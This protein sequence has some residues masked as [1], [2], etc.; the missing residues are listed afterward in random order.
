[1]IFTYTVYISFEK[2]EVWLDRS[3]PIP[4]WDWSR[5]RDH[6]W[7]LPTLFY[8]PEGKTHARLEIMEI[9][10]DQM[11]EAAKKRGTR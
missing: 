6:Y 11:L 7:K 1:M 9:L 5:V 2:I 3:N 4:P 8:D 10:Q